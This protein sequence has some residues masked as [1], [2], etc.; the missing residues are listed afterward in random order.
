LD[1]EGGSEHMSVDTPGGGRQV[2]QLLGQSRRRHA[3]AVLSTHGPSMALADLA[4]EVAVR[5]Q[6][7]RIT[8][9]PA[10]AVAEIYLMLYHSDVPRLGD[11]GAV[12]YDQE[13]DRVHVDEGLAA[14][15]RRRRA[16][17]TA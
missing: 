13:R 8:E 11:C 14:L 5:M 9:I 6:G 3:V 16:F 7:K 15:E 10:E 4:D 12:S 17:R 2:G 1:A